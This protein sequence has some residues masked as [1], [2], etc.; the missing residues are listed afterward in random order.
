MYVVT[1]W[2]VLVLSSKN[3]QEALFAVSLGFFSDD[4]ETGFM[5]Q[6]LPKA[7]FKALT[8]EKLFFFFNFR[9]KHYKSLKWILPSKV[10]KHFEKPI[11]FVTIVYITFI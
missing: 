4:L 1:A 6:L 3:L 10:H 2:T 8:F 5:L 7:Y 9:Q 11:K